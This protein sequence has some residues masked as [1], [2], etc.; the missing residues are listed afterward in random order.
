ML[1]ALIIKEDKPSIKILKWVVG[2]IIFISPIFLYRTLAVYNMFQGFG[3]I[4]LQMALINVGA[5]IA[6]GPTGWCN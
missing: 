2:M 1:K 5:R 3:W 6:Y 4:L